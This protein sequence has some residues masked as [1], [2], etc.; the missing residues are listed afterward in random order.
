[1]TDYHQQLI[2]DPFSF[3]L[4][5]EPSESLAFFCVNENPRALVV[6]PEQY[7]TYEVCKRAL[8]K[9]P[10]IIVYVKSQTFEICSWII[11]KHFA[12]STF[13]KKQLLLDKINV[14]RTSNKAMKNI[15]KYS[16][17]RNICDNMKKFVDF[18]WT[19]DF[20]KEIVKEL[21]RD[22][23]SDKLKIFIDFIKQAGY[24]LAF[25]SRK[26]IIKSYF[27]SYK[28]LEFTQEDVKCYLKYH[29]MDEVMR[30]MWKGLVDFEA[31][32]IFFC[33]SKK[34]GLICA[35]SWFDD[36]ILSYAGKK[37][38]SCIKI[39]MDDEGLDGALLKKIFSLDSID[40]R[41]AELI[42]DYMD[43][44]LTFIANMK[45]NSEELEIV[46]I[47]S[48][49]FAVY[50]TRHC[51]A[52]KQFQVPNNDISK[53]FELALS[54]YFSSRDANMNL[55][56]Y[57]ENY[58]NDQAVVSLS[59]IKDIINRKEKETTERLDRKDH[60]DMFRYNSLSENTITRALMHDGT[61][62]RYVEP[63]RRTLELCK[64]AYEQ[65]VNV[66]QWIPEHLL[67]MI[68]KE[69]IVHEVVILD[70]TNGT[71]NLQKGW[72]PDEEITSYKKLGIQINVENDG[73]CY[74]YYV[75]GILQKVVIILTT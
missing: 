50:L 42:P 49:A 45:I 8:L 14:T 5:K 70:K 15:I 38:W 36:A 73:Q 32:E 53:I 33:K 71:N 59:Q 54:G 65:N 60:N 57:I 24:I 55:V 22:R 62:L 41:N 30:E 27:S 4:L 29:E 25:D 1:M 68:V 17:I 16:N 31:N 47:K 3:E 69:K 39:C 44:Y 72:S 9:D 43:Q 74:K 28:I 35:D 11:N 67:N 6:I 18:A 58:E 51:D 26:V 61:Y 48:H 52:A 7:Q 34:D 64:S 2:R 10:L 13:S 66:A 20:I 23:V 75:S 63:E 21:C 12:R 46:R 40:S 19:D 37:L 56:K